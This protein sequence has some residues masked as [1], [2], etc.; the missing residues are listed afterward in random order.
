MSWAYPSSANT[1]GVTSTSPVAQPAQRSATVARTEL[2]LGP[3][4]RICLPQTGLSLGFA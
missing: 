2:P 1:T 4:T 3:W